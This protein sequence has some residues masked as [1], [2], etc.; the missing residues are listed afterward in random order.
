MFV[1]QY[2]HSL[3]VKGRLAIPK[4]FREKLGQ[5]AV[6]TKGL[7][8]C[9]FL[10][11]SEKWKAFTKKLAKLSITKRDSRSFTRFLTYGA[12]EIEFD[13]QGRALIPDHLRKFAGLKTEVVVAGALER[14]EIWDRNR[15]NQYLTKT[16]KE[17]EKIAERL[18]ALG[19]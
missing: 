11:S 18:D 9:L 13:R 4:K 15:F 1:G 14:V 17:S 19:I 2:Q 5:K 7:D 10:F 6:I 3:E 12:A 16:E 8:G